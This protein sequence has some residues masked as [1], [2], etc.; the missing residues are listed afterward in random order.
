MAT[1]SDRQRVATSVGE[2]EVLYGWNSWVSVEAS[3]RPAQRAVV[4]NRR[5]LAR[6]LA[7]AGVPD[8]EARSAAG[9]LWRERPLDAGQDEAD[10]WTSPWKRHEHGP[11][12]VF[13]VGLVAAFVCLVVLKVDWVGV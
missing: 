8:H 3:G 10:P 7:A 2:L 9:P 4:R 12:I 11:L 13:L 1:G 6:L 5:G